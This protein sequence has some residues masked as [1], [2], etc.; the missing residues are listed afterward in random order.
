[1]IKKFVL[2][3]DRN[4]G[5]TEIATGGEFESFHEIKEVGGWGDAFDEQVEVIGHEAVGMDGKVARRGGFAEDFE[6]GE[7]RSRI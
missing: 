7:T 1:V 5:I 3:Q 4:V 6:G 2:P